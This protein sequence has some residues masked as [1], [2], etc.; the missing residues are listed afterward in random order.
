MISFA[1]NLIT[2]SAVE[3]LLFG[4]VASKVLSLR[5]VALILL[6]Y[7]GTFINED[8]LYFFGK[9]SLFQDGNKGKDSVCVIVQNLKEIL[10]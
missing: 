4:I 9:G 10:S 8:R 6:L 2:W 5:V 3:K 7:A 1:N